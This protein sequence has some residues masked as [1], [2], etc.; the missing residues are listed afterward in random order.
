MGHVRRTNNGRY[1]ARYRGP[2]G[3]ERSKW[4]ATRRD[5]TLFLGQVG[6]DIHHGDWCDP[7]GAR[8]RLGDWAETW[9]ATLVGLRP[10]SLARVRTTLRNQVLPAFGDAPLGRVSQFEVRRWVAQLVADGLAPATVHK[11]YQTLSQMM[12][13]A[14]DAGLIPAS[15]CHNVRLPRIEREEMRFL[16]PDEIVT[17]AAS[18]APRYRALVLFDAHC[19]LRLGELAGLR[20]SRLDLTAHQVRVAEVVVE[21]EG[22][23]FTGPPKTRAGRRTV[24]IPRFV[25]LAM[26]QHLEQYCDRDPDAIVFGGADGGALRANAWRRRHWLPAIRTAG[27]APLRPHDLRHTAVSLWIAAGASPKQIALWAGHTSV[28]VVLDRYGHLF[29]GHEKAVLDRLDEIGNTPPVTATTP[30]APRETEESAGLPR[31]ELI[32]L[33]PSKRP[34]RSD[35]EERSGRNWTRTSDLRRVKAAL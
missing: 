24:P 19:G 35:Q 27:V 16:T 4:F 32:E 9:L 31:G 6:L 1:E 21:V 25:A 20:R 18:I 8:L 11:S 33:R 17:L 3:R 14:V 29:P 34:R 12:A 22:K 28:S 30:R 5:A 7:E 13:A 23:L 15:A 26:R 10:S 2:D